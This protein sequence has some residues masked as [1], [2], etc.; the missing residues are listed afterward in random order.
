VTLETDALI[1]MT[2][3]FVEVDRM[4]FDLPSSGACII[5][6]YQTGSLPAIPYPRL[7]C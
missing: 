1:G 2:F 4:Y 7:Y 3:Y 5:G 6:A